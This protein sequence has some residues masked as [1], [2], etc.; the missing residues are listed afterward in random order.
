M[1]KIKILLLA[2]LIAAPTYV[3]AQ[4]MMNMPKMEGPA[5]EAYM[6]AM[7]AMH[8]KMTSMKPTGDADKDFVMMMIPHHQAAVDMAKAQLEHGKDAELK[9]MAQKI[10]ADQNKEIGEMKEWQLKHGM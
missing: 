8:E 5:G 2:A 9:K 10:V 3:A 7:M 4:G 6:K 1:T